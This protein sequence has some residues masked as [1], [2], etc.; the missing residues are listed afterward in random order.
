MRKAPETIGQLSWRVANRCNGG[1]CIQVAS[2][3][4]KVFFSD[5]KNPSGPIL[6]YSRAEWEAFA[7]G[8]RRGDFDDLQP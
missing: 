3:D 1:A 6:T 7:E 4:D 2:Q 5:S 8:I